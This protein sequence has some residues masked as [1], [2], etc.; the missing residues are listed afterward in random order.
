V[1][2]YCKS[3]S[4]GIILILS[5]FLISC[6]S[7]KVIKDNFDNSTLIKLEETNIDFISLDG[8]LQIEKI[9]FSKEYKDRKYSDIKLFCK[10]E[11]RNG[12]FLEGNTL[13]LNADG[14]IYKLNLIESRFGSNEKVSSTSV[15]LFTRIGAFT[16]SDSTRSNIHII[17]IEAIL[18]KDV[19][20]AI[21]K[22]KSIMLRIYTRSIDGISKNTFETYPRTIDNLKDF[23][24]FTLEK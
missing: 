10:F 15:I 1:V 12:E 16:F 7:V 21:I 5:L 3:L 8:N 4:L 9:I 20:D 22:S 19:Q 23:I 2:F 13:E 18:P 24:K 17:A 14:T 11:G 6:S